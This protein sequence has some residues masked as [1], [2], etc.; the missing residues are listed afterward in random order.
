MKKKKSTKNGDNKKRTI[1]KKILSIFCV[2]HIIAGVGGLLCLL[3]RSKIDD[4]PIYYVVSFDLNGGTGDIESQ[5]IKKGEKIEEPT[6]PKRQ[7]TAYTDYYFAGWYLGDIKR[8]FTADVV[9]EDMTLVAHWNISE[10]TAF[11]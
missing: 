9:T 8:D 7:S 6:A 10:W 1:W 2:L 11:Y 3:R 5:T 4:S